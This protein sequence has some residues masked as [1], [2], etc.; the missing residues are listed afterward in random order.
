M[1]LPPVMGLALTFN[2]SVQGLLKE[3]Q[4]QRCPMVQELP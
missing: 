3:Q 4:H 2:L 1:L